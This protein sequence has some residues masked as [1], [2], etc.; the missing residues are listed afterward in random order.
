MFISGLEKLIIDQMQCFRKIEVKALLMKCAENLLQRLNGDLDVWPFFYEDALN[1]IKLNQCVFESHTLI[2]TL[3]RLGLHKDLD[4]LLNLYNNK[5]I[6]TSENSIKTLD[7]VLKLKPQTSD[8]R[9]N[10]LQWLTDQ[11]NID[12]LGKYV[13]ELKEKTNRKSNFRAQ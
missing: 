11:D 1:S 13:F 4:I 6:K 10:L 7:L 8:A 2:Q 9:I 12:D 5:R 3:M